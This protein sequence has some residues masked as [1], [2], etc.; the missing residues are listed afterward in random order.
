MRA[1]RKDLHDAGLRLAVLMASAPRDQNDEPKGPAIKVRGHAAHATIKIT[2][3]KDRVAGM[4]DAV[5][6]LDEDEWDT[7]AE[8]RRH[9]I[10]DHEL[11]HLHLVLLGPGVPDTDDCGR[12]RLKM[13]RHDWEV[14]GFTEVCERHKGEAVEA[15]TVDAIGKAI[16]LKFPWG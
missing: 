3:L 5:L 4:A 9:A 14:G 13:R 7:F 2:S 11:T 16:Q 12:P 10:I 1:H 6:I 8:P 15:Q